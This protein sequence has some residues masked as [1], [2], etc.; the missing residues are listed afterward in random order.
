MYGKSRGLVFR[1]N[2]RKDGKVR[3]RKIYGENVF[4]DGLSVLLLLQVNAGGAS[5]EDR[6]EDELFENELVQLF[7]EEDEVRSINTRKNMESVQ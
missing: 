1:E 4:R 3:E 2:S 6:E 7:S 5:A